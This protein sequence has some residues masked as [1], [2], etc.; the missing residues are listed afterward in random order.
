M[1]ALFLGVGAGVGWG[2]SD[3]LGGFAGRKGRLFAVLAYAQIA[4]LAV[5]LGL[6][7]ITSPPALGVGA[8][9]WAV[10]AGLSGGAGVIALYRGMAVG[11]MSL[12]APIS[13]MAVVVPVAAGLLQGERPATVV[14]VGIV[15]AIMGSVLA[16]WAPGKASTKGLGMAVLAALGF[17]FG[18]VFIDIAAES[19]ALWAFTTSR[20]GSAAL[21]ISVAVATLGIPRLRG[22]VG[23]LAG[24]AGAVEASAGLA[25]AAATTV[26]LLSVVSVLSSLY[27][28][29]TLCLAF[30]VLGERLGGVQWV[31]VTLLLAGVGAIAAG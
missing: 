8:S 14:S 30:V 11:S 31:A 12:I 7:A 21:I 16:G 28:A 5:M 24:S 2:V 23:L 3:F 22:S 15:L 4:G 13:A 10:L 9:A 29:V 1:S 20:L 19:G 6:V 27:P 18:F 26:G 25:F 17:G